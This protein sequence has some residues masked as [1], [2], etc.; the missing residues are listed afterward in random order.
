[1]TVARHRYLRRL[2][3]TR[4]LRVPN[5]GVGVGRR[6]PA[7]RYEGRGASLHLR[8]VIVMTVVKAPKLDARER[9]FVALEHALKSA[10]LRTDPAGSGNVDVRRTDAAPRISVLVDDKGFVGLE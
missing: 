9:N 4:A 3:D 5:D 2:R 6:Q 8:D 1:M 10:G 7:L